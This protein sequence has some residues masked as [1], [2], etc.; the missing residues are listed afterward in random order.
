MWRLPDVSCRSGVR[1]GYPYFAKVEKNA[2]ARVHSLYAYFTLFSRLAL[3]ATGRGRPREREREEEGRFP[4]AQA[5][6]GLKLVYV[7]NSARDSAN[8]RCVLYLIVN[9]LD[10]RKT[11]LNAKLLATT[12]ESFARSFARAWRIIPTKCYILVIYTRL[13]AHRNVLQRVYYAFSFIIAS[14]N[15]IHIHYICVY[16]FL[17]IHIY[18]FFLVFL[19]HQARRDVND[20]VVWET[21][22]THLPRCSAIA[23]QHFVKKRESSLCLLDK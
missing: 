19:S 8:G 21:F 5:K 23:R 13:V 2:L 1:A 16:F 9:Y 11:A 14:D 10:G 7:K 4:G 3:R 17:Y 12:T 6:R 22:P 20:L 18:I 15:I